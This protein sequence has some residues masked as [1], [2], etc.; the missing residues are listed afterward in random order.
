MQARAPRSKSRYLAGPPAP[1]W[2]NNPPLTSED[3][4]EAI[5]LGHAARDDGRGYCDMS[6]ISPS[7]RQNRVAPPRY[8]CIRF[9]CGALARM[10][11]ASILENGTCP[12]RFVGILLNCGLLA[13]P[14]R[15]VDCCITSPHAL[16]SSKGQQVVE[17]AIFFQTDV[18]ANF[19]PGGRA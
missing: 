18:C 19:Q 13:F 17:L 6:Q 3:V 2:H 7:P 14:E 4:T 12:C 15:G 1:R 8:I 5:G 11:I 10:C 16:Q 9:R